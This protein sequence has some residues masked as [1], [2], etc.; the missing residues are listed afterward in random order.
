MVYFVFKDEKYNLIGLFNNGESYGIEKLIKTR[1]QLLCNNENIRFGVC[2]GN[3]DFE[4]DDS[5][6]VY[7]IDGLYRAFKQIYKE[8]VITNLVVSE[9]DPPKITGFKKKAS[10]FF[11]SNVAGDTGMTLD[12]FSDMLVERVQF[13]MKNSDS[14]YFITNLDMLSMQPLLTRIS[15]ST[16]DLIDKILRDNEPSYENAVIESDDQQVIFYSNEHSVMPTYEEV[17]SIEKESLD[18]YKLKKIVPEYFKY[19]GPFVNYM[20]GSAEGD[21]G[22]YYNGKYIS[23]GALAETMNRPNYREI[24]NNRKVEFATYK[25]GGYGAGNVV[26]LIEGNSEYDGDG[27]RDTESDYYN[28]MCKFLDECFN[29]DI[30]EA[31]I[32]DWDELGLHTQQYLPGLSYRSVPFSEIDYETLKPTNDPERGFN[33]ERLA[34]IGLTYDVFRNL[35]SGSP[36]ANKWFVYA[37]NVALIATRYYTDYV[38]IPFGYDAWDFDKDALVGISFDNK[39]SQI[40]NGYVY[41]RRG[42]RK[43]SEID[44]E[45]SSE[46]SDP[47]T[48]DDYWD[49]NSDVGAEYWFGYDTSHDNDSEDDSLGS[50]SV[51]SKSDTMHIANRRDLLDAVVQ[52]CYDCGEFYAL[53]EAIIKCLR[54]G[55]KK[56]RSLQIGASQKR[57]D[58]TTATIISD[59]SMD[60]PVLFDDGMKYMISA[61]V[62]SE[63]VSDN[64]KKLI[65][66]SG[67]KIVNDKFIVGVAIWSKYKQDDGSIVNVTDY[68]DMQTLVK[69]VNLQNQILNFSDG[70]IIESTPKT[71]TVV[72]AI[73]DVARNVRSS[74]FMLNDSISM[75]IVNEYLDNMDP[76]TLGY[77]AVAAVNRN[78]YNMFT[79][80]GDIGS[81]KNFDSNIKFVR[82]GKSIDK[83]AQLRSIDDAKNLLHAD[84]FMHY[85]NIIANCMG[86]NQTGV[87]LFNSSFKLWSDESVYGLELSSTS[88]KVNSVDVVSSYMSKIDATLPA[89]TKWDVVAV[90]DSTQSTKVLFY[91]MQNKNVSNKYVVLSGVNVTRDVLQKYRSSND[92]FKVLPMAKIVVLVDT[93]FKKNSG[94]IAVDV[95]ISKMFEFI[96]DDSETEDM[97]RNIVKNKMKG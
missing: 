75:Q 9:I 5:D 4:V 59:I 43:A 70:K 11:N 71:I 94:K 79:F 85:G 37:L 16:K 34:S 15:K 88:N 69:S 52:Y 45:Q 80:S 23:N 61:I 74:R 24:C 62:L 28:A 46:N 3:L 40:Y 44:G 60:N 76:Q 91:M 96:K 1:T 27:I 51:S 81:L 49:V 72:K 78:G 21:T 77:K 25:V 33:M 84:V 41:R 53:P 29:R 8:S 67:K 89:N 87:A 47:I 22:S 73:E 14:F 13:E 92:N 90:K 64:V 54:F 93:M 19:V 10:G 31:T 82:I 17:K 83:M 97:F 65:I 18:Q 55:R 48:F 30:L 95:I 7:D 6:D 2:G 39:Y 50:V 42:W 58:L 20:R 68:C 38:K 12:Q 32:Y 56:P 26:E 86:I 63:S 57:V 35:N 66:G 36:T